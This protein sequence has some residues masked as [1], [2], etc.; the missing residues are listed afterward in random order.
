MFSPVTILVTDL[1]TKFFVEKSQGDQ[2]ERLA[3]RDYAFL[4]WVK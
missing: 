2:F 4:G 1:V 3:L